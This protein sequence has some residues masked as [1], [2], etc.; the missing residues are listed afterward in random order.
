MDKQI[1]EDSRAG[2]LDFL[3]TEALEAKKG[4]SCRATGHRTTPK[5]REHY[6]SLPDEVRE[7]NQINHTRKSYAKP[8][9]WRDYV[10]P[11]A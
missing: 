2:T 3:I 9:G 7:L 8:N 10:E 11:S 5:F 1:E 4:E 6:S